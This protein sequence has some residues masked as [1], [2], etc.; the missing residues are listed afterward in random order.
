MPTYSLSPEPLTIRG[1][2]CA[3]DPAERGRDKLLLGRLVEAG[4]R[5]NVWLDVSGEQVVAIFGKRGT[6]KSYTL[7]VV[8]EG[9]A[10]GRGPHPLAVLP[11]P[12]AGLV[13]DLMDIFWT[14]TIPLSDSGPA[15]L[16]RQYQ[17]MAARGYSSQDMHVRIWLPAGYDNAEIDP[18]GVARLT[19]SARDLEP[20]DWGALFD[21]DIYNEPRGM[22]VIDLTQHVSSG[23]QRLDGSHQPANVNFTFADLLDALDHCRLIHDNYQ[24]TT[25]RS[26]RQRIATYASLPLFAGTGTPLT[27]LLTSHSTA[28]LMLARAP[29]A[30]KKVIVAVLL[31][32][33]LRARRD[34]SLAQKRLDLDAS[35]TASDRDRLAA[36]VS[37]SVPRTWVLMDEAHIIAGSADCSVATDAIVKYAKE[38]RNYGLSLGVATQQPSALDPRLLSQVE[39]LI[40]HQLTSPQDAATAAKAI[41]SPTPEQVIVD[42]LP[43]S[44]EDL[45]RRLTQGEAVFSCG[46]A[47]SLR[48]SCVMS[49]RPRVSAHGG[50]EA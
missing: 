18:P 40:A 28:I 14:T 27:D 35:L 41:R 36:I 30:L 46:N 19:I 26:M 7:G 37:A 50:Y 5:R 42:G 6:G 22:L 15:E 44:V 47:P 17:A 12:R 9:L 2:I 34:A 45:L 3:G 25:L 10:S 38:G 43:A 32:R 29:D 11:T 49:V 23:F 33:I 20:D 48:R 21:L 1:D 8:I 16:R 24:D 39:T 13:L 31:R 4:P